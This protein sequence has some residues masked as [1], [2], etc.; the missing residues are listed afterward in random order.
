MPYAGTPLSDKYKNHFAPMSYMEKEWELSHILPSD[1]LSYWGNQFKNGDLLDCVTFY[2]LMG[3][4]MRD[5]IPQ[6]ISEAVVAGWDDGKAK[7]FTHPL[8]KTE[9]GDRLEGAC[10]DRA[11]TVLD[12][13]PR[14]LGVMEHFVSFICSQKTEDRVVEEMAMLAN[15]YV[16]WILRRERFLAD[17]NPEYANNPNC[18]NLI[19][20]A[21]RMRERLLSSP[22]ADKFNLRPKRNIRLND[23][24]T[25]P[26]PI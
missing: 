20:E 23:A 8:E 18:R 5:A 7:L 16:H 26:S 1:N 15:A 19:K 21:E 10:I 17:V 25:N 13:K 22:Y 9:N 6:V 24:E 14:I 4:V 11:Q 3:N 12:A 2:R